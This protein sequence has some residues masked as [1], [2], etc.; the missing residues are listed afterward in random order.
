MSGRR[1]VYI[2]KV[3]YKT[4]ARDLE[5]EF[6]RYGRIRDFI[7]RDGF[8]FATFE[9]SRDAEEAVRDM[10]G[11]RFDGAKLIV[12][13]AKDRGEKGGDRP[14]RP[15]GEH[16]VHVEGLADRTSWQDLKDHFKAVADV[17]RSD[18]NQGKGVIEFRS[19]DDLEKA[20]K[21][22]DGSELKGERIRVVDASAGAGGSSG[23]GDAGAGRRSRSRSPDR[24]RS[25]SRSRS[26]SASPK[27]NRDE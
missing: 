24:K 25:P 18:V 26:R 8:A 12:E 22:L 15:R 6:A 11:R 13:F 20:I 4:N 16:V 3:N 23:G 10:D 1:K 21:E 27:R 2:G 19:R 14:A 9:S 17:T 7:M 5:D